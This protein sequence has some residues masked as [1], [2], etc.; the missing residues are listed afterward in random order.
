MNGLTPDQEYLKSLTLLYVEDEKNTREM[1]SEFLSR[2]VGVLITAPDGADGWKAYKEH[3]PDIVITD[4][5]M[6]VMDGLALLREIRTLDRDEP[7]P[8]IILTAF[9]QIEY[10]ERSIDL[11]LYKYL[12]KPIDTGKLEESLLECAHLLLVKKKLHDADDFIKTIVENVRPPLIV[13]DSDLKIL[14]ANPGFY[15]TLKMLSEETIGNSIY[16]LGN[17][18]WN[19]PEL[20]QLFDKLLSSNTSFIDYEVESDFPRIGHKC[21]LFSA[22]QVIWDSAASNI[23]LLSLEDVSDRRQAKAIIQNALEYAENIVETVREPMMVLNSTLKVLSANRNFYDTFKVMPEETIGSF[24]FDLGNRQWDIPGLRVLL[25]EILPNETVFN[26]YEV[27][28]D[29]PGIG[30]KTILLN[31]R[32]IFRGDIG[33][34]VILLAMEDI[35]DRKRTENLLRARIHL[36]EYSLTHSLKEL[37]TKTLDEA[38][39]LTGSSIGFFHFLDES[40]QRLSLQAWSSNTI[41]TICSTKVPEGHYSVEMAG[42]WADSIRNRKIVTHNCYTTLPDRKG[43][44]EG[45]AEVVREITIPIFRGNS[46]VAI[47]GVGNKPTNY[48]EDDIDAV[49]K[50]ANLAWDIVVSKQAEEALQLAK[51]AAESANIAKTQFLHNMSHEIRTPLNGVIGMS[52]LLK[53][54][55]L[56]A[57]QQEYVDG[58]LLSG[59]NLL[60]LI[61]DILDLAKIE[62]GKV[63][64]ELTQFNLHRCIED[65]ILV[66]K[67]SAREKELVLNV[68]FAGDV[69]SILV[70]DQL[71]VKQIILNLIGNAVK[72]TAKGSITI[73]VN[74]LEQHD[75]TMLVQITVR[76]TGVGISPA[77]LDG[78][79]L[80]FTQEDGSSTRRYG[81]TGL[82][83]TISRRLAELLGGTITVESTL[84]VGSCFIVVLPFSRA[85]DSSSVPEVNT[86]SVS[87][88]GPPLK[89]LLVEDDQINITFGTA[90]L[91]KLG[92]DFIVVTSGREC[93]TALEHG[94]F[95]LVLMDIYLPEI[96]GEEALGE[97]RRKE[98]GTIFHQPVIA[99]TAY[100]M[101]GEKQNFLDQGFDGYTSK[102][103]DIKELVRE[104]KRVVTVYGAKE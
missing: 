65:L 39:A 66:M 49:A 26:N 97:I 82:G 21:F 3:N 2:L 58:L 1:G 47:I 100:S 101:R 67:F 28:H 86:T 92:H 4:I 91:R 96:N 20:R 6:P 85:A 22:R 54:T 40:Q 10:L 103:I 94:T 89:I 98:L 57:E 46:I 30:H 60:A 81:G 37:L 87:W 79:F 64:V 44:P 9:E 83:L 27:E 69:P 32:Q 11:G 73:S 35:S 75:D 59:K 61:G 52:Q 42:V 53:M 55:G 50:L 95:D 38:E 19:T 80:P 90:L 43:M 72:F 93:L 29:F 104:M 56:T 70:G 18:Q 88:D 17:R 12:I 48:G 16:D 25:A 84:R 78:I 76:D 36:S 74:L 23:I 7:V 14:F 8:I 5:Q 41:S 34:H 102:P 62:A 33:Q 31:A 51:V 99:L 45:H 68:D 13:L 15:D 77:A 24:I 63:K 71:R